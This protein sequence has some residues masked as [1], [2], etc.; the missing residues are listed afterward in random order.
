MINGV[1]WAG[2]SIF[3]IVDLWDFNAEQSLVFTQK[4]AIKIKYTLR[5]PLI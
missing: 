4:C 1:R 2:M 5:L 3:M